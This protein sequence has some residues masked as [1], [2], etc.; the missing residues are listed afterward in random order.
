MPERSISCVYLSVEIPGV[1]NTTFLKE[2]VNAGRRYRGEE[3]LDALEF[4]RDVRKKIKELDIPEEM[5]KRPVN[6]GFSGGEKKRNEVLQMSILNPRLA[7]LD[8]TT[9]V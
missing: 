1:A 2:A 8:G 9:R 7:V 3:E 5:L 4:V 6:V